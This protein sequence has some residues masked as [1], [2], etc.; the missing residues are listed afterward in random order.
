MV[1]KYLTIP[2]EV[3][4]IQFNVGSLSEIV[5]FTECD[6]FE[7]SKKSDKYQLLLTIS[8]VKYLIIE[9]NY[10]VKRNDG[11]FAVYPQTDFKSLFIIKE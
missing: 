5:M 6:N 1:N 11:S 3:E 7:L 8:G 10:I 2:E 4:A 9:T